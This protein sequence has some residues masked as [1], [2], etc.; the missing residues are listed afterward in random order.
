MPPTQEIC[1]WHPLNYRPLAVAHQHH[2]IL[3][4]LPALG[5]LQDRTIAGVAIGP[6]K[7][8]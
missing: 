4:A 3:S 1:V 5:E 6:V 2:W 8:A 7:Q